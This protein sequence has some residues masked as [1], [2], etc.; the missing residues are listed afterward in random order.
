MCWLIIWSEFTLQ[1]LYTPHLTLSLWAS[2]YFHCSLH[3]LCS[4]HL[5]PSPPPP[6][7]RLPLLRPDLR[8][9]LQRIKSGSLNKHSSA[10]LGRG[11]GQ[12]VQ[13]QGPLRVSHPCGGGRE[14]G[15]CVIRGAPEALLQQERM[16]SARCLWVSR[17]EDTTGYRFRMHSLSEAVI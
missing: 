13:L 1:S 10:T 12:W 14:K 17:K 6:S 16:A 9:L 15:P 5:Q 11:Q 4:L 8:Q 7:P 3:L 2:P